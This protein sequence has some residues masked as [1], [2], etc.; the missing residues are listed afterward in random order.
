MAFLYTGQGSQYVNMLGE[1]RRREPVVAD[2]F[3]EADAI[4]TPLLEGSR[5]SDTMFAD[6]ADP[7]AMARAEKGSCIPRSS[8]R[9]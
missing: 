5:L 7:D 4:M 9:P 2:T 8:S 1:L 3:D 6:P